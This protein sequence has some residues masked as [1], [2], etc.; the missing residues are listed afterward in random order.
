M[1]ERLGQRGEQILLVREVAGEH[2]GRLARRRRDVA[3]RRPVKSALGE[4][5]PGRLL[6][7][8]PGLASLR[9]ERLDRHGYGPSIRSPA[10]SK[11]LGRSWPTTRC[12]TSAAA[13][14]ACRST[15]TWIPLSRN[16]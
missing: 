1:Q 11:E 6:D 15:S 5:L 7:G 16:R 10:R 14:V 13:I 9:A 8:F 12:A 4:Q 3:Q 2:R